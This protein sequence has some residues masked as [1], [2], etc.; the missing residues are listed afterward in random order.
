MWSLIVLEV[1]F[2]DRKFG[3]RHISNVHFLFCCCYVQVNKLVAAGAQILSP[4]A[5][6]PRKSI[7]TVVDYAMYMYSQV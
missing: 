4:V 6:G 5:V 2:H 7:G 3:T 1:G